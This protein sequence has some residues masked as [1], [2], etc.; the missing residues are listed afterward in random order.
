MSDLGGEHRAGL[1]HALRRGHSDE[2]LSQADRE[3]VTARIDELAATGPAGQDDPEMPISDDGDKGVDDVRALN[4][5][6]TA[7]YNAGEFD[8]A[9]TCY[10]DAYLKYAKEIAFLYG[11]CQADRRMEHF[12][13][14]KDCYKAVL[15]SKLGKNE[16]MRPRIKENLLEAES[17]IT[18]P[19][20]SKNN[21]AAP[22]P[23]VNLELM[24]LMAPEVKKDNLI[25]RTMPPPPANSTAKSEARSQLEF[26]L[27]IGVAALVGTASGA[28]ITYGATH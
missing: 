6:C 13:L 25:E 15:R 19:G 22:R 2:Q 14:A 27:G 21:N 12:D 7:L 5:R 4:E 23:P 3:I 8:A 26:W 17:K 20:Q 9:K 1:A 24:P 11:A 18:G 16:A 28:L 10:H